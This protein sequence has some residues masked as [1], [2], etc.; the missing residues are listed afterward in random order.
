MAVPGGSPERPLSREYTLD[1]GEYPDRECPGKAETL[2]GVAPGAAQAG[3]A[4]GRTHPV[5]PWG[6]KQHRV[7]R[8]VGGGSAV[9]EML[10][11]SAP[12]VTA[13][14]SVPAVARSLQRPGTACTQLSADAVS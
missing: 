5:R 10:L 14:L 13:A 2:R 12:P 1:L 7:P 11:Y 6:V 4:G 8:E 3:A 9:G